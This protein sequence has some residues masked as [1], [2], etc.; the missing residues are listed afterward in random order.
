MMWHR[1]ENTEDKER[2]EKIVTFLEQ[3]PCEIVYPMHP[4]TKKVLKAFDLFERVDKKI[5]L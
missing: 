1:Q 2:M 3:I 5:F 4:R